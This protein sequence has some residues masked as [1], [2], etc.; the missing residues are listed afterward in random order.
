MANAS[1]QQSTFYFAVPVFAAVLACAAPVLVLLPLKS[2]GAKFRDEALLAVRRPISLSS[3]VILW[4]SWVFL[5]SNWSE[6]KLYLY[7]VYSVLLACANLIV[8]RVA[9]RRA[10]PVLLLWQFFNLLN[11]I[12]AGT[13]FIQPYRSGT[14]Y[15]GMIP[16]AFAVSGST[17]NSCSTSKSDVDWCNDGWITFQI[18][19]AFP[20]VITHIVVF[21]LVGTRTMELFGGEVEEKHRLDDSES[22]V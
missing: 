1:P 17:G 21:F 9:R 4:L 8:E 5:L 6:S 11:L 14:G 16:A 15:D 19:V 13:S 12:G 7:A 22:E 18:I 10:W 2:A 20:Y 3:L